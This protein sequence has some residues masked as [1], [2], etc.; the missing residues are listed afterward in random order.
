MDCN[1]T[2]SLDLLDLSMVDHDKEEQYLHFLLL[3]LEFDQ[4]RRRSYGMIM[5]ARNKKKE[6]EYATAK[7]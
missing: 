5:K 2:E 7:N 4:R 3:C 6:T 1:D